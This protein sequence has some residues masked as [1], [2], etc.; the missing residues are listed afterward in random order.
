M[1][2]V[3]LSREQSQFNPIRQRYVRAEK[4]TSGENGA[5]IAYGSNAEL[6]VATVG[7]GNTASTAMTI[8]GTV[9][10]W[11]TQ[12]SVVNEEYDQAFVK[13]ILEADARSPEAK[14]TNVVDMMKWL[15]RD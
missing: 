8:V 4:T 9:V 3:E 13:R 12:A 2:L 1:S 11:S 6:S 14:F 10:V 15:E 5:L 7:M